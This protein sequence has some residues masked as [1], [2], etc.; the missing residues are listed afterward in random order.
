[1]TSKPAS[2][3][4]AATALAPRSW[5]SRPG[6]ATMI[7]NFLRLA[8]FIGLPVDRRFAPFSEL[9]LEGFDPFSPRHSPLDSVGQRR[10]E[11]GAVAARGRDLL[12]G[13]P[14]GTAIP[15]FL[16]LPDFRD[17]IALHPRID[18]EGG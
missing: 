15:G 18:L 8:C 14:H 13:V 16:E 2:R 10:H 12:Q 6:F 7:R 1:M 11:V 5:P 9:G 17:L 4:A 3:T